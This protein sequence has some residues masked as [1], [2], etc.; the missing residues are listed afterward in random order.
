MTR[1]R[2]GIS[3]VV[4]L[5]ASL[6]AIMAW[7]SSSSHATD[8]TEQTLRESMTSL[9]RSASTLSRDRT[10][11]DELSPDMAGTLAR[12]PDYVSG[13]ED[14]SVRVVSAP[15]VGD[16]YVAPLERGFAMLASAGF[17]GTVPDGLDERN[18]F[19]AGSADRAGHLMILGIAA[20]AVVSLTIQA[21]GVAYE[22][23]RTGN[24][25]WW[26]SP[27]PMSDPHDVRIVA[28]L[29]DGRTVRR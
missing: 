19:V 13:A 6:A 11:S 15:D 4:L 9:A 17:A 18:P 5:G 26:V 20:D 16:L 28:R 29:E 23:V 22:P 10:E 21:R 3:T 2:I 7:T 12:L 14:Q 1:R 27:D 8:S 24:G 25:F